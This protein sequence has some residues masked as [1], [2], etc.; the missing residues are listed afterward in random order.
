MVT[1]LFYKLFIC[2]YKK[3]QEKEMNFKVYL[4]ISVHQWKE[5]YNGVTVLCFC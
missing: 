5:R 2:C 4:N 1:I 3:W